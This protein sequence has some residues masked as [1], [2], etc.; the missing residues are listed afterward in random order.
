MS[1]GQRGLKRFALFIRQLFLRLQQLRDFQPNRFDYAF[2]FSINLPV[3]DAHELQ[4][5]RFDFALPLRVIF[6]GIGADVRFAV[7]FDD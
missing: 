4:A 7:Y 2:Q 6:D 3:A 1:E 5:Q